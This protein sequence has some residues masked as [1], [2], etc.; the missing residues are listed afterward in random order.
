MKKTFREKYLGGEIEFEDIDDYTYEWG[1]NDE[2]MT[3]REYLGLTEEEEDV[4]ISIGEEALKELLDG[5]KG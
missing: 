4:W 2:E 3:L 5:Q 1:M